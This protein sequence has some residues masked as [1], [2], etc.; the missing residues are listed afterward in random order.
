[1]DD[2]TLVD[3]AQFLRRHLQEGDVVRQEV[4]GCGLK[5]RKGSGEGQA[6][7]GED[8]QGTSIADERIKQTP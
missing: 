2:A 8:D 3:A 7:S 1:M 5:E 6:N 4:A